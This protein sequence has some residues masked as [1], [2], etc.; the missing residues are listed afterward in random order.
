M[1]GR[2]SVASLVREEVD[3]P[4]RPEANSLGNG[5]SQCDGPFYRTAV[6]KGAFAVAEA[7]DQRQRRKRDIKT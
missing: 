7:L 5:G 3:E 6:S 1:T 4:A 2:N